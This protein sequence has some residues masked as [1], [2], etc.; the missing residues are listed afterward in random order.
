MVQA[1]WQQAKTLPPTVV[2]ISYGPTWLLAPKGKKPDS[3]LL[4]DFL[5]KLPEIDKKTGNPKRRMF[6][7]SRW[8]ALMF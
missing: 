3:G 4:E 7:E 8:A 1:S 2:L 5:A 6:W